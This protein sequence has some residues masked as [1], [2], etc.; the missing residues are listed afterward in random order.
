MGKTESIKARRVDV[1][2]D[3]IERKQRWTRKADEADTSLSKFVQ[4]CV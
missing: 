2:L 3:T 4:Q 1:Y